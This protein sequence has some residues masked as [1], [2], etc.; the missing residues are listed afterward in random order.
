MA[1]MRKF[2]K[3]VVGQ[4]YVLRPGG[5]GVVRDDGGLVAIVTTSRGAFL[6]GG[7][8]ESGETPRQAAVPGGRDKP[9]R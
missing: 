5:Y 2:G 8:Q 6:L 4:D 1:P 7:G 3:M 9:R